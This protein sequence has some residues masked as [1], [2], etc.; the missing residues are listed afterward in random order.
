MRFSEYILNEPL[1]EGIKDKLKDTAIKAGRKLGIQK[2]KDAETSGER[3][4]QEKIKS[5]TAE[6]EKDSKEA[7]E[8]F[9]KARWSV[10]GKGHTRKTCKF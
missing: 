10:N 2:A 9:K 4:K 7:T 5:L 1:D 6:I 8:I 3:A